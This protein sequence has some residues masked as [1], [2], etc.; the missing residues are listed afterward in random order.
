MNL[1]FV[2]HCPLWMQ[3]PHCLGFTFEGHA[4]HY[5]VNGQ[6]TASL[7]TEGH[8]FPILHP[9]NCCRTNLWEAMP[10]SGWTNYFIVLAFWGK[11]MDLY[12]FP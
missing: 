12:H 7:K 5:P 3:N 6:D 9:G 11:I 8:F 4:A 10:Q 2:L 1:I